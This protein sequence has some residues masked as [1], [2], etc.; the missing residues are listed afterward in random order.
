MRVIRHNDTRR[1]FDAAKLNPGAFRNAKERF[2][3]VQ[4]IGRAHV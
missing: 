4:E 2:Q 3:A 1:L